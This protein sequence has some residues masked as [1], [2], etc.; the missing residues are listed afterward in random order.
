M[1]NKR[2]SSLLLFLVGLCLQG[3]LLGQSGKFTI[4]GQIKDAS[5][6]EDIPFATIMLLDQPGV[7]TTSNVYGFYSLSVEAGEYRIAYQFLGYETVEKTINLTKDIKID[8]E[9]S[10]TN[11]TLEQVVVSAKKEDQNITQ[12]EGSVT[13]LDMKTIKELPAFGGEVDVLKVIQLTPGIKTAGE[14]NSGFYVRGGGLDQNLILLDEAPVYNPSHLLGFFSVFNGDALKSTA[15]YKGGMSAEYGGRTSSV[16]DIRMKDG[17]KKQL[18]VSGGIGLIASRLTVEAPI[19]KDKGS[20]ILSGRRTYADLFLQL[21]NDE[22]INN[23]QLYFYD[24]N[25]KANYRFSE[26]D[27]VYFSGYLGRDVLGVQGDFGFNWGNITST[28]RWNHLFSD[29]LFSNTTFIFS[30]YDYQ[31]SVNTGEEDIKLKSIIKDFNLKQDFSYYPSNRNSLKFGFNAI[32]HTI[33][34]G[35]LEAGEDTGFNSEDAAVSRGI[36]GAVYVQNEQKIGDRLSINYGLRYSFLNRIGEGYEYEFAGDGSL[37]S[38]TF[39]ESGASMNF[40]GGLEPR[41]SAN[42]LLNKTSSVKLGFNRNLQYIHLLTNATSSTPTDLWIMSSNNVKPQIANQISLGYFRNFKD[43]MYEASLE[44]YYKDLGNVIDYRNGANVFFNDQVEGDLVFG[45]GEAY[46]AEFFIKKNKG[47]LT[48]W[49]SY[50]VG[51]TFRQIEEINEGRKFSARQDRIHD[52]SVV[53]MYQFSKRIT[54]SGNFIFYTGDAVTYPTGRYKLDGVNVPLYTERNGNRIPNYHRFDL[55]MTLRN[56]KKKRWESSWNFALYNT[57]ARENA[58]IITFQTN[59]DDPEQTEALQLSLF[60]IIPS[61][62][63]NFKF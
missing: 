24:T 55:S 61:V 27:R 33:E 18:G 52:I 22:G 42:F 58:Y 17:N 13:R 41:L 47:K 59:E 30:N 5:N 11:L 32:H 10:E 8:I 50:T 31:F 40:Q 12:N 43:N 48:G 56:K 37:V 46:G 7:G 20:F 51:R 15:V 63:Y 57:Y 3:S 45:D 28:V 19:V 39:Y 4:S 34:P 9:L 44:V 16:I 2:T 62:T 53:A 21:S 29:K 6:G 49:V 1:K 35:N 38:E 25:L 14:G 26:K 54:F 23:T 36:E 60:K